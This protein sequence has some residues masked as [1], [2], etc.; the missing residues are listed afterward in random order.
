[1]KPNLLYIGILAILVAGSFYAGW[2]THSPIPSLKPEKAET[3][4][5]RIDGEEL[6]ILT[7]TYST[8]R[9]FVFLDDKHRTGGVVSGI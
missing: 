7:N 2:Y 3:A 8:N 5:L 4:R 6:K 1:M 9:N